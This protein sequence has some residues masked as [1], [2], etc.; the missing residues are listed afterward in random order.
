MSCSS[1]GRPVRQKLPEARFLLIGDGPRRADLESLAGQ[2]SLGQSVQFLGTRG[3]VP[4]LLALLDVLVLTSHME[5]NPV[6]ILEA[7]AA[8]K[9]VISTRVGSV[10]ETVLDGKTGY[11]VAPGNA[12]SS[13]REWRTAADPQRAAAMGHAGREHVIAIGRSIAWSRLPEFAVGC[14]RSQV[15]PAAPKKP[16]CASG[17]CAARES[18]RP[19]ESRD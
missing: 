15:G 2:L 7:M 9:P 16:R 5:A 13:L 19:A 6:S 10:T 1:G 4:E 11:L 17:R 12:R 14:L 8:E 18:R 3:D